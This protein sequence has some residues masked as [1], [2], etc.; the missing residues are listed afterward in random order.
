MK[1]NFK[2]PAYTTD[3]QRLLTVQNDVRLP[4]AAHQSLVS[5]ARRRA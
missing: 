3:W 2:T 1:Q 5:G 4:P